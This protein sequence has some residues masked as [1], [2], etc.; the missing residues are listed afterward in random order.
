[1]DI[2]FIFIHVYIYIYLVFVYMIFPPM[3]LQISMPSLPPGF[4]NLTF[5]LE[6]SGRF[7]SRGLIP[8]V[9]YKGGRGWYKVGV[10]DPVISR[11]NL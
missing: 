9:C 10:L 8:M 6:R 1:M 5:L 11:L 2:I 3:V 7:K 4:N